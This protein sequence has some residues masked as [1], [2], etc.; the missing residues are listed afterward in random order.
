[1]DNCF[2]CLR[3][4]HFGK[5]KNDVTLYQTSHLALGFIGVPTGQ[6]KTSENSLVLERTPMTLNR[7]GEWES[8]R[9]C[10]WLACGVEVEHQTW[11]LK[12][13]PTILMTNFSKTILLY[14]YVKW[15]RFLEHPVWNW[16][17]K[18]PPVVN[19]SN[20]LQAPF[21]LIFLRPKITKPSC[22]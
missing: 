5:A 1:M 20:I 18:L 8:S 13:F 4:R 6:R 15:S 7:A 3:A 2:S 19:F 17:L 12:K 10:N 21:M 16:L 22:N 11:I 14:K 9:I